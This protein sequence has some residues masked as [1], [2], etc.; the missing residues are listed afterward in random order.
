MKKYLFS[1]IPILSILLFTSCKEEVNLIGDFKETAI[2][3][4]LLDQSESTHLIKINRAFI[5]PGNALEIAK[6]PDSSYFSTVNATITEYIGTT[7]TGKS[8]VLEDT[9]IT[10]KSENGIFY[11]PTEK[12][13]YFTASLNKDATYKLEVILYKG[14]TKEFTVTGETGLVSGIVSGQSAAGNSFDFLNNDGT[15]KSNNLSITSSGNA[16]IVNA[17][18]K[19]FFSEYQDNTLLNSISYNWNTGE[20]EVSNGSS[21]STILSGQMFYEIIRD[22]V[23]TNAAINKRKLDSLQIVITGGAS[24]FNNYINAN[25]PSSSLAQSKPNYTNLKVTE[26]NN[27]VG[28][29]SS[30]QTLSITKKYYTTGLNYSCLST[31]SREYLCVGAITGNLFFKSN[32]SADF[33]KSFY[34][35]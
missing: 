15:L 12:V 4:G 17:S 25:K 2:I 10:N 11:A 27:V 3:Y 28:I 30:R 5:G 8:W 32:H 18:L 24:E 34:L 1:L 6:I 35:P 20:S 31:R 16:A 23:T 21:F 22:H 19:I 26:G 9:T 14:T 33:G 13:Y 29:F 7:K